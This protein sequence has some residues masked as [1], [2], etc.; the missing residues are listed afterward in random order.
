MNKNYLLPVEE[1]R[2]AL[3]VEIRERIEREEGEDKEKGRD[4]RVATLPR[5]K[6][7]LSMMFVPLYLINITF[8]NELLLLIINI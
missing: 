1:Q 2:R 4:N 7:C 8:I 3:G 5:D 6:V